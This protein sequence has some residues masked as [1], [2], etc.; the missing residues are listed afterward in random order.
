MPKIFWLDLGLNPGFLN[1]YQVLCQ[2]SYLA[3]GFNEDCVLSGLACL[4]CKV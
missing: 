1:I 2:L 3:M 4:S